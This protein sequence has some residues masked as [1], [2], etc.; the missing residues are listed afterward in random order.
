MIFKR[1]K[2]AVQR[3]AEPTEG[4]LSRRHVALVHEAWWLLV[5]AL[6]AFLALILA[7]YHRDRRRL[8]LL[9]QRRVHPEQGW[10][11][12]RLGRRYPALSVRPVG[13]VVGCGGHRV[14]IIGYRR[15]MA[16][17]HANGESE[18]ATPP[19][20]WCPASWC[21]CSRVPRSRRCACIACR[22]RC[23]SCPAARS[24]SPS[25]TALARALGFN[26]ATL[27]LLALFAVGWSLLTGMS[28][29]RFMEEDRRRHRGGD[30]LPAQ[31]PRSDLRERADRRAGTSNSASSRR[32]RAC[33]AAD[34]EREPVVVV[35]S[36]RPR[37]QNPSAWSR[38]GR[39]RC[40]R[41]CR[42][43]RLPPLALLEDAPLR[44]GAR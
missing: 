24:A 26:G 31:A 25:A 27:L 20:S 16:A 21:C 17:Q 42:I 18:G 32:R 34:E 15:M 22:R 5:V 30:R 29:L 4:R 37:L 44:A 39:S 2:S 10:R 1:N 33:E 13:V 3:S 40:S 38:S 14:V 9:R 36:R 19:G 35:P 28:W 41:N 7:T 12:R 8:V 43:R 11:G 6:L 23:R